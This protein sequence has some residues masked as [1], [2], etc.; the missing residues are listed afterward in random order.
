MIEKDI[1]IDDFVF[2]NG[3]KFK[4]NLNVYQRS[5]FHELSDAKDAFMTKLYAENQ[6]LKSIKAR[7]LK[8][9]YTIFPCNA[10]LFDT[11]NIIAIVDKFFLDTL[12]CLKCIPDDN[13]KVVEYDAPPK[14]FS[15]ISREN[16]C[17]KILARCTFFD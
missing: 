5:H 15:G 6:D 4:L 9:N 13:Y 8:L 7:H 14:V 11:Q 16:K 3:K 10:G 2:V 17:N 12:V 1:L